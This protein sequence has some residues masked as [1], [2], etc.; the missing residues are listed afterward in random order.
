MQEN[1]KVRECK[2]SGIIKIF[3]LYVD[4]MKRQA[5]EKKNKKNLLFALIKG[6][7]PSVFVFIAKTQDMCVCVL[8]C[9]VMSDSL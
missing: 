4:M 9:S 1:E 7:E 3:V 8:S 2:F 5:D 6:L